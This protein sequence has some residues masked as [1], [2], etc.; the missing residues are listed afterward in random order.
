M[1][2]SS[3]LP[4]PS[5]VDA[6]RWEP[7]EISQPCRNVPFNGTYNSKCSKPVGIFFQSQM[8]LIRRHEKVPLRR[9]DPRGHKIQAATGI[10]L[11]MIIDLR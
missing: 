3:F 8:N 1:D 4:S 5:E 7:S 10:R 2:R 6:I 9:W 11:S